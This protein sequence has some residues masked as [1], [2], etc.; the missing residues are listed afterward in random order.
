ML[1]SVYKYAARVESFGIFAA[2]FAIDL[3]HIL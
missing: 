1:L 3:K 2:N